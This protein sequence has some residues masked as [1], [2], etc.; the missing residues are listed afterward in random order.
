MD[1]STQTQVKTK[2]NNMTY[3]AIVILII[4]IIAVIAY[5]LYRKYKSESSDDDVETAI[6]KRFAKLGKNNDDKVMVL[7]EATEEY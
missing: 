6:R 5:V 4:V 1:P 3:I 2:S 7:E